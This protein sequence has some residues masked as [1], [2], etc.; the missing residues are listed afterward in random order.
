MISRDIHGVHFPLHTREPRSWL[1]RRASEKVGDAQE[2]H[3][4]A[5]RIGHDDNFH[6]KCLGFLEIIILISS[7]LDAC[8]PFLKL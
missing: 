6:K 2:N 3:Q 4:T 7:P 5:G 8:H 1:M